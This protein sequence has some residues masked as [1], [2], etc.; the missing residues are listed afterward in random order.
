MEKC[1]AEERG[2]KYSIQESLAILVVC[3][4]SKLTSPKV[5]HSMKP[6]LKVKGFE[7]SLW[8]NVK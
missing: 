5:D 3:F 8:L 2:M 1:T 7:V 4:Q 6:E